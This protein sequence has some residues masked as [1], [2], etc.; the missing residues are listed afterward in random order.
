MNYEN[1]IVTIFTQV[2]TKPHDLFPL[3][4]LF[5]IMIHSIAFVCVI[6]RHMKPYLIYKFWEV[7]Q[8]WRAFVV[9]FNKPGSDDPWYNVCIF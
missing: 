5:A 9:N 1:Y 8:S 6:Y 3:E 7:N 2:G 4:I